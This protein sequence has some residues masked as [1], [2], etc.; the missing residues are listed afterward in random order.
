ML[1]GHTMQ[2]T[3][4][5]T[6][7][8]NNCQKILPAQSMITKRGFVLRGSCFCEKC[9]ICSWYTKSQNLI[10]MLYESLGAL[11]AMYSFLT[12]TLLYKIQDY[13]DH[14]NKWDF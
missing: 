14:K 12:S 10:M 8:K 2:P 4:I 9:N 5:Y 13:T 7:R 1:L 3:P 11:G 6:S